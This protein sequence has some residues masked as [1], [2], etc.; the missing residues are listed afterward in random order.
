[1]AL[2]EATAV[3]LHALLEAIVQD[4]AALD[5]AWAAIVEGALDEG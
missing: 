4:D 3:E 1:M 2:R 5:R